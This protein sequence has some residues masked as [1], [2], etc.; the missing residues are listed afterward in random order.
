MD[1]QKLPIEALF[2][3]LLQVE[4]HEFKIVSLSRDK[5]VREICNSKYFQEAYKEKHR[6]ILFHIY[7][8]NE[9]WLFDS[10]HIFILYGEKKKLSILEMF[11]SDYKHITEFPLKLL[12]SDEDTDDTE[13]Y[14]NTITVNLLISE[15]FFIQTN[16]F[17][18]LSGGKIKELVHGE[19]FSQA[20]MFLGMKPIFGKRTLLILTEV[21]PINTI[22]NSD[23]GLRNRTK[24]ININ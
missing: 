12:K 22:F 10:P 13:D 5:K 24:C 23:A 16:D 18:N 21:D 15:Y 8:C 9:I 17:N 4:P 14:L 2:S 6:E 7:I 1:I 11:N 20:E 19:I 3:L